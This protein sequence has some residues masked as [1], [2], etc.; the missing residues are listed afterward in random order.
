MTKKETN[1]E[2]IIPLHDKLYILGDLNLHLD[3]ANGQTNKFNE[4]LAC[5]YLN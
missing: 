3:N 4:I 1:K 5:F 2:N